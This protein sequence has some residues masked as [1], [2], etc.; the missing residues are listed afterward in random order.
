MQAMN[1]EDQ[2]EADLEASTNVKVGH[3]E[4]NLDEKY[5]VPLEL[6]VDGYNDEIEI[7]SFPFEE[8]ESFHDEEIKQE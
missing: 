5:D 4:I 8:E 7:F 6:M 1:L 2:H 3:I